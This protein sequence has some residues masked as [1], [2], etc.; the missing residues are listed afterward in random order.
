[1]SIGPF[2]V[3][4]VCSR[5]FA[6]ALPRRPAGARPCCWPGIC[7]AALGAGRSPLAWAKARCAA[8][9]P[10]SRFP[11]WQPCGARFF[12]CSLSSEGS[13]AR[14]SLFRPDHPGSLAR[15]S[16]FRPPRGCS[17]SAAPPRSAP[18]SLRGARQKLSAAPPRAAAPLSDRGH[19]SSV[20][21]LRFDPSFDSGPQSIATCRSTS[22]RS[23]S[24]R[25]APIH[26]SLLVNILRALSFRFACRP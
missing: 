5:A 9:C 6:V 19:A 22:A 26:D 12:W 21:H 20:Q 25:P 13:H 18:R 8:P 10:R 3:A 14:Y 23:L 24:R 7:P 16:L 15:C 4:L 11:R 2:L 1:M 17:R